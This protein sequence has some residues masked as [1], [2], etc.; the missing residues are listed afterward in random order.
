MVFRKLKVFM[1][2]FQPKVQQAAKS[3]P[4]L[5]ISCYFMMLAEMVIILPY[6]MTGQETFMAWMPLNLLAM[7]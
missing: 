1:K 3:L 2:N 5:L 4:V 7:K 6:L